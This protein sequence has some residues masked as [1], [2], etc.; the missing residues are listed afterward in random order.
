MQYTCCGHVSHKKETV[1][2]QSIFHHTFGH[3]RANVSG[4][5]LEVYSKIIPSIFHRYL[6]WMIEQCGG[7]WEP[8]RRSIMK[9]HE[10]NQQAPNSYIIISCP[11]DLHLLN[12]KHFVCYVCTSEF[13][14]QSIMTQT[15][16]FLKSELQLTR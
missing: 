14:L 13:I 6:R 1:P 12:F 16:D 15:I 11:D 8:N 5:K 3:T 2:E 4:K 9:I 7:K 10:L